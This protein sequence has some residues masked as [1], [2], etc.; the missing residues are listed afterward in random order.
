MQL[1]DAVD[2]PGKVIEA[3]ERSVELA[4]SLAGNSSQGDEDCALLSSIHCDYAT[5]LGKLGREVKAWET[6][7]ECLAGTPPPQVHSAMAWFLSTCDDASLRDPQAAMAHAQKGSEVLP[8]D[9]FTWI[10][11]ALAELRCGQPEAAQS[12]IA[13]AFSLG[14]KDDPRTLA[15]AALIAATAGQADQSRSDLEK[16]VKQ[17]DTRPGSHTA[18]LRR[19]MEEAQ[20][21]LEMSARSPTG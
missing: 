9:P 21:E 14:S 5:T 20:A 4:D 10:T 15:V 3:Y 6:F 8:D 16:A 17:I 19:L 12:S 1:S 18:T 2:Q 7:Q 11:M 13:K